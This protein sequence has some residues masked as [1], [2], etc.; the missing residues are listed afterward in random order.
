LPLFD[1]SLTVLFKSNLTFQIVYH[2]LIKRSFENQNSIGDSTK[3]SKNYDD[4]S[5][6]LSGSTHGTCPFIIGLLN[7]IF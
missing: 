2:K 6:D 3:N 5:R 1:R 4:F 7:G